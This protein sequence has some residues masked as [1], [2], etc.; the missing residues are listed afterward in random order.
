MRVRTGASPSRSHRRDGLRPPVTSRRPL[1]FGRLRGSF[2]ER[3]LGRRSTPDLR[4][5]HGERPGPLRNRSPPW[6]R[7]SP[8]TSASP[9]RQFHRDRQSQFS[10]PSPS[11]HHY[12]V[13]PTTLPSPL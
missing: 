11:S 13:L 3:A 6:R 4:F 1:E 12:S 10:P 8:G 7:S 9:G 5:E 2:P